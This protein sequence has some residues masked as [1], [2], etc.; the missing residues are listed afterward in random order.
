MNHRR[1]L[2]AEFWQVLARAFA[3]PHGS[4]FYCA[5]REDLADD[6][7]DLGNELR[8]DLGGTLHEFS[9]AALRLADEQSLLVAY[10]CLFLTPPIPCR[11]TLGWHL[12]G[13]SMGRSESYLCD[14]LAGHGLVPADGV[15]APPDALPT[16]LEFV[17]LLFERLEACTENAGRAAIE[18][19]IAVLR[20]HYLARSLPAMAQLAEQAEGDYGLVPVYSALLRISGAALEDP[21]ERFF[22]PAHASDKIRP[23]YFSKRDSAV[24]LVCCNSCGRSIAS[25]RELRVVVDRLERVGLP[26]DHLSLCPDCREIGLTFPAAT[27]A[28]TT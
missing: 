12:E 2:R 23:R 16:V 27:S 7:D 25:A 4:R 18:Q 17:A 24:D 14:L 22:V 26:C 10:S 28:V 9:R 1:T 15:A 13:R 6:L 19:D 20:S 11:L 8:L 5:L 21:L 3:V